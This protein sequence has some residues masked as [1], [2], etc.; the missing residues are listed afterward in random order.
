MVLGR[1]K[2]P[3]I[4]SGALYTEVAV[5]LLLLVAVLAQAL[6]TLVRCHFVSLMLLTVRHNDND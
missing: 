2:G 3:R 4:T 1:T 6:F 5:L